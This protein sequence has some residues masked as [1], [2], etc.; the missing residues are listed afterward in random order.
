MLLSGGFMVFTEISSR[1]NE[2][3]TE[4]SALETDKKRRDSLSLFAFEGIKLFEEAVLSGIEIQ[5]VFFTH[6][7][8][9]A[10][11]K[12]LEKAKGADF[13]LVSDGV[14]DKLSSEKSPQGV[15]VCARMPEKLSIDSDTFKKASE[16]GFIIF[17]EIQNPLNVGAIL[18]SCYSFGFENVIFTSGCADLYGGKCV[19]AAMGSLFKINPFFV[20]NAEDAVKEI[21]SFGR[22]VYCADADRS[23]LELGKT[24]FAKS[25]SFIIGN[26]GHGVSE[27][28]KALCAGKVFIPM[29]EGAESLNAASAAAVI[30]WEM[31]KP[32]LI[33]E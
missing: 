16:S 8:L 22:R 1:K 4:L 2:I 27:A 19:R 11:G 18:R 7:A 31:K 30:M 21:N 29:N 23:G 32:S 12:T 25:D 14:Y 26:E 33:R 5:K 20:R 3:I 24:A 28:A 6:K 10:Y 13:Y 9:D 17:D 15:F